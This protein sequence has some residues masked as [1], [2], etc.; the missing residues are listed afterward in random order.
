VR[1][2]ASIGWSSSS[3]SSTGGGQVGNVTAPPEIDLPRIRSRIEVDASRAVHRGLGS[4]SGATWPPARSLAW[5]ELR[6][7][8]GREGFR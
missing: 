6:D 3:M 4:D 2:A 5:L 1:P 8:K 7:E